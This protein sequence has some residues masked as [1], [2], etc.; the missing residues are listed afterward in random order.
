MIIKKFQAYTEKDAINMAKEEMG[1]DAIVLNIKTAKQKGVGRL[2]KKD[3]VEVTAAL[4][5]K[6]VFPEKTVV[7]E[8]KSFDFEPKT[9]LFEEPKKTDI[10]EE[11]LN[12]LQNM[13]ETQMKND[14]KENVEPEKKKE[15]GVNFEFMQ[16][17]YSKMLDN[18]VDEKYANQIIGDIEASLKKESNLD[19][20]LSGVYQKI[21]LKLGQPYSIDATGKTKVIFFVGPTGVGKTTTIAKLASNF[22]I[23][24]KSKVAMIT[25]D[26]FRI[27]AVE[28]LRTYANILDI[29][30]SV[31]YTLEELNASIQAFKGYDLIFVD[32]AG[33]SHKNCEQCEEIFHFVNDVEIDEETMDKEVFLVLSAATKYKDLVK[34][35]QV[36][37]EISGYNL[38]FTKLDETT[39]LGNILNIKLNTDSSLSYVTSGQVV[40]D[41]ISMIDAQKIAKHILGGGE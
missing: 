11:K 29:P 38:I 28:Q 27:A 5:E 9:D 24:K 10:I 14:K 18:E 4:E 37:N 31:V 8:E 32:T 35:A 2:F 15:N 17:I 1:K 21:I 36:Y 41:D 30:L 26:T 16:L 34:I 20:I 39:C 25:S 22:K 23:N 3:F 33:R 12:N 7:K 13:L 40:P 19:T 6:P